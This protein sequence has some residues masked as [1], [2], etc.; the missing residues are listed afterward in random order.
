MDSIARKYERRRSKGVISSIV[1]TIIFLVIAVA[2]TTFAI[3][4]LIISKGNQLTLTVE[5]VGGTS[6]PINFASG[7]ASQ[8]D[9]R[10]GRSILE[11]SIHAVAS[12]DARVAESTGRTIVSFLP[13][14]G[15]R[16]YS[17]KFTKQNDEF[18]STSNI[19]TFCGNVRERKYAYCHPRRS[20]EGVDTSCPIGS[21]EYIAGQNQCGAAE[22]CCVEDYTF[23]DSGGV[24]G[25]FYPNIPERFECGN[26]SQINEA[27][28]L[29]VCQ[30]SCTGGRTEVEIFPGY[31]IGC[32][33]NQVCCSPS[34][35][36]QSLT[37]AADSVTIPIIYRQT[38]GNPSGT[39]GSVQI[40]IATPS[41]VQ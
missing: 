37:A 40:A 11:Q 6:N 21:L 2:V 22:K 16:T 38:P 30:E 1:M 10:E 26:P 23:S 36:T 20:I 7:A 28:T 12:G 18:A 4:S 33:T 31:G 29:G 41:V 27:P 35:Q 3:I 15:I 39:W 34:R 13:P 8:S 32:G 14:F 24:Q 17:V 9:V 25:G 5:V 19:A